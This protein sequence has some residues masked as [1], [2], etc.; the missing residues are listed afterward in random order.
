MD[1]HWNFNFRE[2]ENN[3]SILYKHVFFTYTRVHNVWSGSK[4]VVTLGLIKILIKQ[5]QTLCTQVY[6]TKTRANLS[7][8]S[9]KPGN[10][11]GTIIFEIDIMK[12]SY[13]IFVKLD[14][15]TNVLVC[16][17]LHWKLLRAKADCTRNEMTFWFWQWQKC[18]F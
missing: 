1:V 5:N 16:F 4:S 11:H 3:L 18:E 8:Y 15:F 12:K 10:S 2:R 17:C 6:V 7:T 9:R 14:F 13:P